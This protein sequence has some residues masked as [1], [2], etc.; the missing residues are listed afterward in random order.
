MPL[1]ARD[2]RFRGRE[3]PWRSREWLRRQAAVEMLVAVVATAAAVV[4]GFRDNDVA[5]AYLGVIALV[6]LGLVAVFSRMLS[7]NPPP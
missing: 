5:S 1:L 2:A 6:A 7:N 3:W 4:F